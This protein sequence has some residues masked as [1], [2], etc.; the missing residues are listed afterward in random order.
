MCFLQIILQNSN[1]QDKYSKI[2]I[3]Y[4]SNDG[5]I[6]SDEP[7]DVSQNPLFNNSTNSNTNNQDENQNPNINLNNKKQTSKNLEHQV[8]DVQISNE[9]NAN[10]NSTATQDTV[11]ENLDLEVPSLFKDFLFWP[12]K[13]YIYEEESIQSKNAICTVIRRRFEVVQRT[14]RE[15]EEN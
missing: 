2:M 1:E 10:Q 9:I 6:H 3:F 15:K 5:N 4:I 8:V 11:S 7:L 13:K 12:K 14:R